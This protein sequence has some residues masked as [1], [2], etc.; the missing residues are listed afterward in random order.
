[1]SASRRPRSTRR[2][3]TARGRSRSTRRSCARIRCT[4]TRRSV[5]R[6]CCGTKVGAARRCRS[7][8][9][10]RKPRRSRRSRSIGGSGW[11]P[12][13]EARA[14]RAQARA[15]D[16]AHRP[17]LLSLLELGETRPESLLEA[18][19]ALLGTATPKE[20]AQLLVE[21]GDLQIDKMEDPPAAIASYE[22]ALSL[23]P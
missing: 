23:E 9:S 22:E 1:S 5:R 7:S 13:R 8:R 15:L 11:G 2:S 10:W 3:R 20:R 14:Q 6:S 21:I 18:K 19:R 17:S 16:P 12:P 4:S